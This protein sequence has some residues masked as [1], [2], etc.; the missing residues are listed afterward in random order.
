MITASGCGCGASFGWRDN[1]G[2]GGACGCGFANCNCR[3][4]NGSLLRRCNR[5]LGNIDLFG[6]QACSSLG[7]FRL[8]PSMR[9]D[10]GYTG[11]QAD[12]YGCVGESHYHGEG[13]IHESMPMH[14][15][16][17][18]MIQS[19]PYQST[20]QIYEPQPMF[21]EPSNLPL[22]E[23]P[24][25]PQPLEDSPE[26]SPSDQLPMPSGSGDDTTAQRLNEVRNVSY[27]LP[28]VKMPRMELLAK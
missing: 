10:D 9:C 15:H 21:D 5:G 19:T 14:N 23:A 22:N 25:G 4:F 18:P 16:S 3:L 27:M 7:N 13:H 11:C 24:I 28:A 17:A 1:C 6:G 20:P 12:T 2:R 8:M 26:T